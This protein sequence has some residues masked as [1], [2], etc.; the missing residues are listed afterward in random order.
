MPYSLGSYVWHCNLGPLTMLILTTRYDSNPNS[1]ARS[2]DTFRRHVLEIREAERKVSEDDSI[3]LSGIEYHDEDP[4]WFD[5][6]TAFVA[7]V[8]NFGPRKSQ[9]IVRYSSL[10]KES[11][12]LEK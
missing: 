8:R 2:I 9:S 4:V 6:N 10:R 12:V 7:I 5:G 1:F 11:S 3:D